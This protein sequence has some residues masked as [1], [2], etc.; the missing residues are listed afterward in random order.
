MNWENNE[1]I[2]HQLNRFIETLG[3]NYNS[4]M[5]FHFREPKD[6]MKKRNMILLQVVSI[7]RMYHI[8]L[9]STH[10]CI[11]KVPEPRLVWVTPLAIKYQILN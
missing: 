6:K 4:L 7:K 5:W 3:R 1:L 10:S 9:E 11:M 8:F 2:I